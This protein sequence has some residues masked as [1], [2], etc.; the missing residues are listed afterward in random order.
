MAE[1]QETDWKR[2]WYRK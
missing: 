1:L 2:H